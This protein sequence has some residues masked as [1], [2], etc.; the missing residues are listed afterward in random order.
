MSRAAQKLISASGGKAYEI[1]QSL[2]FEVADSSYLSKT[3]SSASNQRTWTLSTWIKNTSE[4]YSG[5]SIWGSHDDSTQSDA[6]YGWLGLYQDKIQMAGWSTVWRETNRL[7]R[8]VG[9][10]MHLVV[11]VDTTIA[12]GSADNRIRIY[13]NG[14]EE[15]SFAV[16][17]NP[18]QN[19]ELP[20]NKNQEHRFGAI[21][22]STAYY[23]GGYFAETQVIDG[24]QLT[25]S[26]FGETDAVTGQ[27]IPKEP[28]GLTY[29]TNGFYLKFASG[30]IGTDSSGNGN[31]YT[32]NNLANA[33]VMLDTPT[34]NFCT[35]N[36][37]DNG[38]TVLSQ[39]NLKFVNSSGN[40]D[41]GNTFAIPHTGKWYFEH[42]LTV[43]D[44]YYAGLLSKGY[45]GTAGSYS[46]FTALQIRYDGQWYNG[47]AF[48]S[49]A[50]SFSNGDILGWAIDCDNGKVYVSVNGTFA[51]SGNPVNGTNPADTFTA[52][53]DWKF[54]TYGNS[55]SQFDANFGQNGTFNGLV[56]AQGNAD[57][58]GIGN[59]YYAPPSSFK[60]LTS[61]NLP[62][63]TIKKSTEY[64][65]IATYTGTGSTRSVTGLDH[66]PDM[67]WTKTRST[68]DDHRVQDVVRGSTKHVDTNNSDAEVTDSA[69]I[70]SFN[71]DGFTIGADSANRFNVNTTTYVAWSWKAGG[72]S[73]TDVTES[74]SGTSRIN[75][76]SRSVNTDAGFSIIKYTGSNDEISNGEHTKL[77]HGLSKAPDLVIIKNLD[78][79]DSWIV[80][81]EATTF[82]DYALFLNADNG[83]YGSYYVGTTD[84]DS[85][86]I[87]LGNADQLNKDGENFI[88]YAWHEVEGFSKFGLYE[89]N[90]STNGPFIHTGFTPSWIVFKYIDGSGEWWWML[91]STRDTT[92]LTTEVM[93]PNASSAES[94]IGSSGGVDFLSNGFKIRATN[95]G[96]NSANT[97]FYMAF[98]QSF[99]YANAR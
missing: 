76:S 41:T 91:D 74:G 60:A 46:G 32:A 65:D 79:T 57:G 47:S 33:D 73:T 9:A 1:E 43:V 84:P 14:V 72:S 36:S 16:K 35:W 67:L 78:D 70:T 3:P 11:A 5:G 52:T 82:N 89:S 25:P 75:A 18:S 10:W 97:Y 48:E 17:N 55:G 66:Q 93:Y 98:G 28:S 99:K 50:S 68:T 4:N 38:S 42:R 15:T 12:D 51:N 62:S 23:F 88:C 85:T 87:Y 83:L 2:M 22:R 34:N 81:S 69:G 71:S 77:N 63:V 7:F 86:Y 6:G 96:I 44:A 39:G 92:N 19:T 13:I 29:G 40:S 95:G 20:W 58:G 45:T 61:K 53:D 30:A 37:L 59:F 26:S 49:Y 56:T 21:N 54:I 90:N 27:W 31:N 24:S 8:D 80:T 64:F 94:S